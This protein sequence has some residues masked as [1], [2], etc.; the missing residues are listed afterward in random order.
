MLPI[1]AFL[2]RSAQPV[3][4]DTGL[5]VLKDS[6]MDHLRS[7]IPLENLRWLWLTHTD[8]DHMGNLAQVLIEAPHLRVITTFLGMGKMLLH[9][10]PVDR[11]SLLNPGQHLDI[12]DRRLV[13]VRPPS[14]DAPETTGFFDTKTRVFFSADCFGALMKEPA[15]AATDINPSDLR[16]GLVT[17]T[18]VDSPWLHLADEGQFG[19]S[20]DLVR[21]LEPSVILSH[22]L[23]PAAGITEFLLKNLASARSAPAFLG[24]DQAAMD[25]S[26]RNALPAGRNVDEGTNPDDLRSSRQA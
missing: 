2:I 9:Q 18:T 24:P 25:A 21:K 19:R 3:L 14:F 5:G 23:P 12:G 8:A 15:E 1:N 26:I 11:V 22:H 4:V 7:L 16:E 17:W 6:F 13:A 10:L 20:L